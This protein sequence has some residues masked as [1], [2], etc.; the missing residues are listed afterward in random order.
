MYE[1]L[2]TS[3]SVSIVDAF[4]SD[5]SY[6][7]T[8]LAVSGEQP[9]IVVI[10]TANTYLFWRCCFPDIDVVTKSIKKIRTKT[11]ATIVLVGPHGTVDPDW[12]IKKSKADFL[13]RGEPELALPQ[14]IMKPDTVN[15]MDIHTV[16]DLTNLPLLTFEGLCPDQ[17][18]NCHHW[19]N[20][21]QTKYQHGVLLEYSRGCPYKCGFCFREGFREQ[22]R[23]KSADQVLKE[24]EYLIR[25][26]GVD[27]I[28]FIDDI[29]NIDNENFRKLLSG[30]KEMN[31]SYGCQC[32]P[33]I[34]TREL[35]D[36]MGDSGCVYIEYG[37]ESLNY[38]NRKLLSKNTSLLEVMRLIKYTTEKITYVVYNLLDFT[39]YNR[40]LKRSNAEASQADGLFQ[41]SSDD[42]ALETIV[43]YPK[44]PF[45]EE[46]TREFGLKQLGF[47]MT[48]RLYWFAAMI[49][50]RPHLSSFKMER[51]KNFYLYGPFELVKKWIRHVSRRHPLPV[52]IARKNN[53]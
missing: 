53:S 36:A 50:L 43:I 17:K 46:V 33:D 25:T 30:L 24:V 38:D 7:Q 20:G 51:M 11:V 15:L 44:T 10:N 2:K 42:S 23:M 37:L 5:L 19:L 40:M 26:R 8:A 35:V 31:I 45:A 52:T 9:D 3:H 49:K 48:I 21:A 16:K 27:Y 32:R 28:F 12:T 29:F 22:Y 4:G 39:T 14:W 47:E 34:M 1:L 13:I 18:Y 6:E 41:I